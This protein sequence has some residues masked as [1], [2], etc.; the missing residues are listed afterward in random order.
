[1]ARGNAAAVLRGSL[2]Q[3]D[4]AS[5]K[6]GHGMLVRTQLRGDTGDKLD[7]DSKG[8]CQLGVAGVVVAVDQPAGLHNML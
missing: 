8:A 4:E 3:V 5:R 7:G 1:M 6:S 2:S